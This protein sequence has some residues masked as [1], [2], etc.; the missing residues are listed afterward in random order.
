MNFSSNGSKEGLI[1]RH[2]STTSPLPRDFFVQHIPVHD[3]LHAETTILPEMIQGNLK[4]PFLRVSNRDAEIEDS[5]WK[6]AFQSFLS[7]E[8]WDMTQ[9]LRVQEQQKSIE[10]LLLMFG[11]GILLLFITLVAQF[12]S[13]RFPLIILS[14][15]PFGFAG[16]FLLLLATG[17]SLNMISAIGLIIVSGIVVNDAILK[18]S[19]IRKLVLDDTPIIQAVSIASAQRKRAILLTSA[20]TILAM[21]PILFSIGAGAELQS[22]MAVSVIGGITL[23]TAAAMWWIPAVLLRFPPTK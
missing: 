12:N 11:I 1:L 15:I 2:P 19:A 21:L 9:D 23:G 4:G 6:S 14:T 16:S 5:E 18:A 3:L 17:Q 20:T 10:Q 8:G 7:K 22:P 13:F